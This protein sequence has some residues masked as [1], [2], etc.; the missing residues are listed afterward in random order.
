MSSIS[1][2]VKEMLEAFFLHILAVFS[3]VSNESTA[4]EWTSPE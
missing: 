3:S 2:T 4:D 1:F